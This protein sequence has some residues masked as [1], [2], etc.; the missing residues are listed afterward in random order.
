MLSPLPDSESHCK[1]KQIYFK[2]PTLEL[3]S[4][5][6]SELGTHGEVEIGIELRREGSKRAAGGGGMNEGHTF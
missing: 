3:G 4:N 2:Q 5:S 6:D 1:Y